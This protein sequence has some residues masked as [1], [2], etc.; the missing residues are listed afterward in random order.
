MRGRWMMRAVLAAVALAM[1]PAAPVLAQ[2]ALPAVLTKVDAL[3]LR[4]ACLLLAT[5][6]QG[7]SD[8]IAAAGWKVDPMPGATRFS[9]TSYGEL[10]FAGAGRGTILW[11]VEGYPGY[12]F[13]F[14]RMDFPGLEAPLGLPGLAADD[15]YQGAIDNDPTGFDGTWSRDA[16][17][18][19]T[20]ISGHEDANTFSV[21]VTVIEATS[22]DP[23]QP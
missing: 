13:G 12:K 11:T 10:R 18:V 17:G 21:Q 15:S 8:A 20:L 9:R 16:G 5:N 3:S 1:L 14:C 23:A 7:A 2:A 4:N 6:P 19:R 22:A